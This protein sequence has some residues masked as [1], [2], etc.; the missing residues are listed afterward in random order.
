MAVGEG[1][2]GSRIQDLCVCRAHGSSGG[3]GRAPTNGP[4]FRATIRSTLGGLGA[5]MPAES[6]TKS[7]TSL[8]ASAGLKR[9]SNPIV[10]EP[11]ELIAFPQREPATWP[12]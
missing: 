10:V 9:R 6:A 4:R 11:F 1:V 3:S 5:E 7:A 12:G 8:N 2:E